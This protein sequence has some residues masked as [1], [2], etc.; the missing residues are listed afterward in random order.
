MSNCVMEESAI[1]VVRFTVLDIA[2]VQG[3]LGRKHLQA[4]RFLLCSL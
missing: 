1:E 2:M 3:V 4:C